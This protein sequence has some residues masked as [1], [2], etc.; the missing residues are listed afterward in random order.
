MSSSSVLEEVKR[1]NDVCTLG[2][3]GKMDEPQRVEDG[4]ESVP[5]ILG[6]QMNNYKGQMVSI[7]GKV[8]NNGWGTVAKKV[9]IA[10]DMVEFTVRSSPKTVI[11]NGREHRLIMPMFWDCAYVEFEG[12]ICGDGELDP[13]YFYELKGDDFSEKSFE[14]FSKFVSLTQQF[15]NLF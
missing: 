12:R 9:F 10:P 7:L 3:E 8:T 11:R 5:R 13:I 1:D 2:F 6:S 15:P 14:I 4:Y